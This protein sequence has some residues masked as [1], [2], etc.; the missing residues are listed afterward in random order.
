MHRARQFQAIMAFMKTRFSLRERAKSLPKSFKG[1]C[2]KRRRASSF[3]VSAAIVAAIIL[4]SAV[5]AQ[6]VISEI[7]YDYSGAEE[8]GKHDWVEIFNGSSSSVSLSGWRLRENDTDHQ[9][10]PYP[11]SA[12]G[13]LA[14]GGYAVGANDAVS[15]KVDFPTYTGLLFDSSFSLVSSGETLVMR[16]CG[17]NVVDR[18]NR[19]SVSYTPIDSASDQGNTLQRTSS[20]G[21]TFISASPTP[22]TG[23]LSSS[24]RTRNSGRA[25]MTNEKISSTS[26]VSTGTSATARPQTLPSLCTDSSIPA[27]MSLCSTSR[28]KK[29]LRPTRLSSRSSR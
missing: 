25:H 6:V 21:I 1:F 22:G 4:P 26:R 10:N 23:S 20:A 3:L 5:S 13:M 28:K 14:A 27:A 17:P 15:F 18:T 9:M 12:S 7:M 29:T 24:G 19:D 11:D 2:W 16:C 8:S